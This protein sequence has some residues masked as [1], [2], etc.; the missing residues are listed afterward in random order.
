MMYSEKIKAL[1]TEKKLSTREF[2][3]KIGL[4][5]STVNS[6]ESGKTRPTALTLRKIVQA[7]QLPQDYF[8]TCKWVKPETMLKKAKE[9]QQKAYI[10][11]HTEKKDLNLLKD[12]R[13]QY[14]EKIQKLIQEVKNFEN[15]ITIYNDIITD[16]DEMLSKNKNVILNEKK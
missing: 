15:K 2:S 14:W 4:S 8:L 11:H 16:I 6:N 3:K 12:L 1:R 10:I 13:S 9:E 5:Q 7:F